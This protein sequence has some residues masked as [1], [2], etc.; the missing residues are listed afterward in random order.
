MIA[1]RRDQQHAH[2]E[3]AANCAD[4]A[5]RRVS[6]RSGPR[7]AVDEGLKRRRQLVTNKTKTAHDLACDIFRVACIRF[8]N[9]SEAALLKQ[10]IHRS[11]E[12]GD[13]SVG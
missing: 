6:W 7:L 9:S 5:S 8:L 2:D 4:Q 3:P 11:V 12:G 1:S 13:A 10:I